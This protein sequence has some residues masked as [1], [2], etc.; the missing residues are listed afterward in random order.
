MWKNLQVIC[1][2]ILSNETDKFL[3]VLY[4]FRESGNIVLSII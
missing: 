2:A 4:E 1:L 3:N